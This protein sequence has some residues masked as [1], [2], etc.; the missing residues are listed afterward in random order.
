MRHAV[1][2]SFLALLAACT[3]PGTDIPGFQGLQY[4]VM[5]YYDLYAVE[6][7]WYCLQPRMQAITR[8]TIVSDTDDELVLDVHFRW[9]DRTFGNDGDDIL[10]GGGALGRCQGWS[11]RRFTLAKYPDDDY[12]VVA[13]SGTRR[14]RD[15]PTG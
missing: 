2:V 8:T 5:R 6:S 13:M 14:G 11:D 15:G 7:N 10:F 3:R 9:M 1:L 4:D 12:S